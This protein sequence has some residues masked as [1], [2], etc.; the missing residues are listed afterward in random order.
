VRQERSRKIHARGS[1]FGKLRAP[2]HGFSSITRARFRMRFARTDARSKDR[3]RSSHRP[4]LNPRRPFP[5]LS[6]LYEESRGIAA[7]PDVVTPV[8]SLREKFGRRLKA[9]RKLAGPNQLRAFSPAPFVC[10][11]VRSFVRSFSRVKVKVCERKL[12]GT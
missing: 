4:P 7:S 2:L 5:S 3:F 9:S 12:V 11:F 8:S 6:L 1:E 10:S